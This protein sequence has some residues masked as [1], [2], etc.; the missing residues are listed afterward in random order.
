MES[1]PSRWSC[2]PYEVAAAARLHDELG[3]SPVVASVLA[4]RGLTDPDAARGF[5]A[6]ADRHDPA[7]L[8][9]VPQAVELILRHVERGSRIVV[10]GDYDVD[11]VCSTAITLRALR[12]LGADP[13]WELPSRFGDGYGLSCAAVERLAAQGTGL[14]VAVDCGITAVPEVAAARAAGMDVVVADHHR[15]GAKLPECV[16]VH[17]ALGGYGCPELCASGVALKL[18]EAL[19]AAAGHDPGSAAEEDMDLAALGTVCDL[20]PLRGENRRIVREGLGV[21]GR[22]RRPGVRALMG[23]ASVEPA[24]LDERALGFRLG[25][26]LNAAGRMQRADAA[27]ELLTTEDPER[28]DQVARELDGLNRDR[29]EAETRMLF[30]ADAACAVQAHCGAMVVAG[31]GWHPGVVGIVA[32]RLVERWRRP[33]VVI[34]LDGAGGRGSGRSISA[35]DLHAGLSACSEHL[36]RFGGHRVAA[37]L[38]IEADR[39]DSFRDAL[40]CHAAGRLAPEDLLAVERIDAVVPGDALGLDLAE[41]L[42]RLRPF[43]PGNPQPTLLLPA[44]RVE[45]VTGMGE[46]RKHARFTVVS[47]GS[48]SRAVAFGAAPRS[49]SRAAE[50]PHHI[51]VRLEANRW[52]GTVE[53]RLVLRALCPTSSGELHVLDREGDFWERVERSLEQDSPVERPAQRA[54]GRLVDRRG[55]GFAGV[56]GDLLTSGDQVLVAVADIPRR[57]VSLES[58]IAGLVPD[59]LAVASWSA[60]AADPGLTAGFDHLI[61]LDPPP[62]GAQD[63]L[64][65]RVGLG[66]LAWG[67]AEVDFALAVWRGELD[68]RAALAEVWRALRQGEDADPAALAAALRGPGRYPRPAECCARLLRILRELGLVEYRT[69]ADGGPGC[70]VLAAERTELERSPTYR[71]CRERLE[72]IERALEPRARGASP[73]LALQA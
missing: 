43:G 1:K 30:E 46:G 63:P 15:P 25:P 4:R 32:S 24:E 3:V 21:L 10:H 55:D 26:R 67:P 6:A 22:C 60:I 20:V 61:A 73:E 58:L 5:L 19:H 51:A 31:Q 37:G 14:L 47:G 12:S 39:V 9:G 72:A 11:G 17:P 40:A 56:A 71:S 8:P 50:A 29:R 7:S 23:V 38:E 2:E 45:G 28:A 62:G 57:R 69:R 65:R 13:R 52:N 42:D 34:G 70:T 41:E 66:H 27:L 16:V 68:P 64:L 36:V 33:C 49:V 59:G 44:A 53:P 48:R 35:Y 18:S 54:T